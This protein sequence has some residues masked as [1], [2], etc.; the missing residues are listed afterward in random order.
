MRDELKSRFIPGVVDKALPLGVEH[1]NVELLVSPDRRVDLHFFMQ[2]MGIA[3]TLQDQRPAH[4]QFVQQRLLRDF[5]QIVRQYQIKRT[6]S[7]GHHDERGR[8]VPGREQH[9]QRRAA[10]CARPRIY[11]LGVFENIAHSP[12]RAQQLPWKGIIHFATQA[13]D[14]Y[15]DNICITVE[16]DSP[17][18]FGDQRSRQHFP[19]AAHQK[20]QQCEFP[21]RQV[22]PLAR[23]RSF[24]AVRSS[25]RSATR[26]V[27]DSRSGGRRSMVRTRAR[28]SEKANGFTR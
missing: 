5:S 26:S 22:Q 14:V 13:P 16:V 6:D 9:R 1:P 19:G 2:R 8:R 11:S 27:V 10:P 3:G 7:H 15:I 17:H 28:S 20:R 4:I 25:S 21:R 24:V 12:D 18:R 23:S